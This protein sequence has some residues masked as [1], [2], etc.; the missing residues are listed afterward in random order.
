MASG[1][2]GG[3]ARK[4]G[5]RDL[6]RTVRI[7]GDGIRP[8]KHTCD[9]PAAEMLCGLAR[10][11]CLVYLDDV[12]VMGRTFDKH[13]GN[14]REIFTQLCKAGLRLKPSKRKLVRS[15]VK[16][17]GYIVSGGVTVSLLTR[18]KSVQSPNIH[19]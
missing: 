16:F 11:K 5:T 6:C 10:E 1:D 13:L 12:L 17:L 3:L 15:E 19:D 2:G 14:L 9:I 4:D 8:L 7:H 18:R